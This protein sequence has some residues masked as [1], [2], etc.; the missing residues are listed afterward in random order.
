MEGGRTKAWWVPKTTRKFKG[1]VYA[2]IWR[3]RGVALFT[4]VGKMQRYLLE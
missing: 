4:V 2:L 1:Q 3:A